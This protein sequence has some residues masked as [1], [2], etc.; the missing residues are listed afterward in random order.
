MPH[1]RPRREIGGRRVFFGFVADDD[2]LPH[3]LRRQ[4]PRH[5]RHGQPAIERLPAG[6]R[7]RIVEQHFV[8][9]V[10]T[11]RDRRADRQ[12]AGMRVGAV[13]DI[14]EDMLRLGERRLPDPRH[15]FA[16]HLRKG[17]RL[18]VHELRQVVT[19]DAGQRAA[20]FRYTRRGVVGTARAEIG[21]ALKRHDAAAVLP[22]LRLERGQPRGD[23]RAGAHPRQPLADD[24]RDLCRGQLAGRGQDPIA[25]LVVF[26][27]DARPLVGRPV[28]EL[29]LQLRLDD[30]ALLLDDENFFEPLGK[31]ADALRLQRPAHRHLVE[32]QSDLARFPL[33]DAEI[34]ERLP[35][36]EIGFAGR[37]DAKPRRRAVDD[38][39]VEPIGAREGDRGRQFV[40]VQPVFLVERRVGPADV[41]PARRHLDI[42]RQD[43]RDAPGIDRHRGRAVHRLGDGLERDPAAGIAR[44]RPAIDPEID[45]VLDPGRVEERDRGVDKREFRLVRQG[46]GFAGVV[47]A[48]HC[49]DPAM[50]RRPGRIGV[51]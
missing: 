21:R 47:V 24:F 43:D 36:I 40:A 2:N 50:G 18:A 37:D 35:H 38:D 7:D 3:P 45:D 28:V 4:L 11:G 6:H 32:P 41:E 26:A 22:L 8:G 13:A 16:A 44:H 27:D 19:A 31:A 39:A 29:L 9:H 23:R 33:A 20:P 12:N 30:R 42:L 25:A 15:A 46:R 10:D 48:R 17:R 5:D 34:V 51:L 14:G 1:A 49:Q